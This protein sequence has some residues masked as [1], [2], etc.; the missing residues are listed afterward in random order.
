MFRRSVS[1]AVYLSVSRCKTQRLQ[2]YT[3][4]TIWNAADKPTLTEKEEEYQ[5]SLALIRKTQAKS[6][7]VLDSPMVDDVPDVWTSKALTEDISASACLSHQPNDERNRLVKIEQK[8]KNAMQS[9]TYTSNPWYIKWKDGARWRNPLMSYTSV[10]DTRTNSYMMF[11]T[12]DSAIQF[13]ESQGWKYEV[14]ETPEK[15]HE[16]GRK[17]YAFNFLPEAIEKDLLRK[18]KDCDQFS[19]PGFGNSNWFMPL[20]FHG[21]KEVDQHG[22]PQPKKK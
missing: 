21:D 1:R 17:K 16:N 14:N 2:P 20:T 11:D 3:S 18:G 9:A 12:K 8:P 13:A 15:V 5:A 22:D 10:G 7:V 19:Q 6:K 4:S